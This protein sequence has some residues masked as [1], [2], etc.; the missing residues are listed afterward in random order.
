MSVY[1]HYGVVPE[2]TDGFRALLSGHQAELHRDGFIQ[3]VLQQL[4]VIMNRYTD[5][6]SVDDW[7][8]GNPEHTHTLDY[9]NVSSGLVWSGLVSPE[10]PLV[11]VVS[12]RQQCC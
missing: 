12:L 3:R 6:W 8:L 10:A 7:T 5:H 1:S 9:V 2:H 4:L 11:G